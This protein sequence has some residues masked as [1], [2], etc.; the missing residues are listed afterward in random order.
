IQPPPALRD[1]G[2]TEF[3]QASSQADPSALNSG[4]HGLIAR[5]PSPA[6]K[7]NLCQTLGAIPALAAHCASSRVTYPII[8]RGF[9]TKRSPVEP[10][11]L[12][13][14]GTIP[15]ESQAPDCILQKLPLLRARLNLVNRGASAREVIYSAGAQYLDK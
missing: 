3:L 15:H 8:S 12:Q 2:H 10:C 1:L 7:E 6:K 14:Q 9:P 11:K 5:K 13:T 4:T